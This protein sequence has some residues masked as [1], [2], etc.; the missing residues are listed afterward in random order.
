[1]STDLFLAVHNLFSSSQY[2]DYEYPNPDRWV[3]VGAVF[4]F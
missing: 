2:W 3:E 1:M 4:K